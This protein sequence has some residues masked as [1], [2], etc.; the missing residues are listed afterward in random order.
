MARHAFKIDGDFQMGRARQAF[1][2]EIVGND[3][4]DARQHA[5]KDLGSRHGVNRRQI[6]VTSVARLAAGD[7]S[8]ITQKRLG[9]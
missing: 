8:R 4:D 5:L 9:A 7:A 6:H 3:E 1:S 2:L